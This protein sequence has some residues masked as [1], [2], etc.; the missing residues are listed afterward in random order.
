M[1]AHP[2]NATTLSLH[3]ILTGNK[4]V[5]EIDRCHLFMTFSSLSQATLVN[6]IDVPRR[7]EPPFLAL[8]QCLSGSPFIVYLPPS[9]CSVS[10]DPSITLDT[11]ITVILYA[12][13]APDSA[14]RCP[15]IKQLL[16]RA[17]SSLLMHKVWFGASARARARVRKWRSDGNDLLVPHA[18]EGLSVL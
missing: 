13:S 6:F 9:P 4:L 17:V 12:P 15:T 2:T 7:A 14:S 16:I 5:I 3:A 18:E 1:E 10:E 11:G 8:S